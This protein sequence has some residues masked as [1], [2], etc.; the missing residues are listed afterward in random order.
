VLNLIRS[1]LFAGLAFFRTR[2]E[3]AIQFLEED[4]EDA[5]AGD[6]GRQEGQGRPDDVNQLSPTRERLR[7]VRRPVGLRGWRGR[8]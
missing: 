2:H 8:L 5:E 6:R 4:A 3:L 1:L 7:R